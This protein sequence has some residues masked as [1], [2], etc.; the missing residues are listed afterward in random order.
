[1]LDAISP[2]WLD[3][4]QPIVVILYIL[5][6]YVAVKL[7]HGTVGELVAGMIRELRSLLEPEPST[8]KLNGIF[9]ILIFIAIILTFAEQEVSEA[10]RQKIA[11]PGTF[12]F[13]GGTFLLATFCSLCL[14][15]CRMTDE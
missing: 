7:F 9:A 8:R 10:R 5:I 1:M 6:A 4:K 3:V 13:I 2:Y 15:F 11:V 14:A 12:I